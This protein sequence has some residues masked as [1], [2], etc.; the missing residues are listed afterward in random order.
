MCKKLIIYEVRNKILHGK[1][2]IDEHSNNNIYDFLMLLAR[3]IDS[4]GKIREEITATSWINSQKVKELL[5]ICYLKSFDLKNFAMS[6]FLELI[7]WV[8]D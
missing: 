4:A 2:V 5:C 3:L 1:L 7:K 8:K 6:L